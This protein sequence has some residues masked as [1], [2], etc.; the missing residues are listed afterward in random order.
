MAA[1]RGWGAEEIAA[2]L[3]ELSGKAAE[4][5]EPY[6]RVTAEKAAAAC[7]RQQRSRT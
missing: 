2:R 7:N 3:M 1:Q 5:G 6:A 4:N